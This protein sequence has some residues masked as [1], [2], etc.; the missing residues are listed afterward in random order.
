MINSFLHFQ[1][2]ENV[3]HNFDFSS[4]L[5]SVLSHFSDL[6][7]EARLY[8][9]K[10]KT[11]S[12]MLRLLLQNTI[13]PGEVNYLNQMMPVLEVVRTNEQEGGYLTPNNLYSS[14]DQKVFLKER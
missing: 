6:G 3:L 14:F 2:S 9:L 13:T 1:I 10:T 4:S 5:H 8:L 7:P 12:R 11:L